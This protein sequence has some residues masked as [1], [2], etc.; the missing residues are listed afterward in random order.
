MKQMIFDYICDQANDPDNG[1]ANDDV[2]PAHNY[3][4]DHFD[5]SDIYDQI[6]VLLKQYF[7]NK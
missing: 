5:C 6:D 7:A 4:F 2:W 3:V 1:I